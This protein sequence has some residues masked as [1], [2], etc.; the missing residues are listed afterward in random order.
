MISHRTHPDACTSALPRIP[1]GAV[2]PAAPHTARQAPQQASR[3]RPVM[4][5]NMLRN[6]HTNPRVGWFAVAL[7]V[8][9]GCHAS[10][11][12]P[13]GQAKELSDP[14]RRENAIVNLTRLYTKELAQHHGNRQAPKVKAIADVSVG[15]LTD[16]LTKNPDDTQNNLKVLDLLKEMRD[17]RSMDAAIA[18]LAWKPEVTE[19]HA[20]RAAQILEHIPLD[21]AQK[22]RVIDAATQAIDRVQGTSSVHNRL[23]IELLQLLGSLQDTRATP[24]LTKVATKKAQGS[25]FLINRYA[26]E[27]LGRLRNPEAVPVFIRGLFLSAAD[28]PA[29]RANDVAADGLV[30]IGRPALTPLLKVLEGSDDVANA[31]AK[32]LLSAIVAHHPDAART[33][34]IRSLTAVEASYALGQLGYRDS[35]EPL[36]SEA[37]LGASSKSTETAEGQR[38]FAAALALVAI[39]RHPADNA[40]VRPA[41]LALYKNIEKQHRV[42][43][44]IAMRHMVD[45]GLMSHFLAE[46]KKHEDEV[47]DIRRQAAGSYALLANKSEAP[48]MRVLIAAEPG[49]EDGGERKNFEANVAALDLAEACDTDVNCYLGKLQDPNRLVARKAAIMIS[50]YGVGQQPSIAGL[51]SALDKQDEELRVEL[52]SALDVVSTGATN[53]ALRSAI[54]KIDDIEQKEQGTSTWNRIRSMA[55]ATRARIRNRVAL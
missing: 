19:E 21:T 29:L 54:Q 1:S 23:Q 32:L 6:V 2:S 11:D 9:A 22:G 41:L 17:P 3:A 34:T 28:N 35:I 49:P 4:R 24:I 33:T 20:I 39:H 42:Q 47:P 48:A 43:L 10:A 44:L 53:D 31:Y 50:R 37:T 38:G 46:A 45:E 36:L 16:T 13:K 51:T 25:L 8:L 7:L 52:L 18:S 30:A 12:D 5:A 40:R 26:L 55:S 15:P 14:V 27:Q